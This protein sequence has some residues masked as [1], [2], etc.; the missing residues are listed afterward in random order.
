MPQCCCAR[1]KELSEPV[2]NN[3]YLHEPLGPRGN[4]CGPRIQHELRDA[5][6]RIEKLE[7]ERKTLGSD[8][9]VAGELYEMHKQRDALMSEIH[10]FALADDIDFENE[11]L[12]RAMDAAFPA[13]GFAEAV[14]LDDAAYKPNDVF[15]RHG[16]LVGHAI[17]DS[18]PHPTRRGF[19]LVKVALHT[20]MYET[21]EAP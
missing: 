13:C 19:H 3:D 8:I 12:G 5:R 6:R 21:A 10:A 17:C 4:F 16:R 1:Y 9:E 15:K 20:S 7:A 11:A 14:F 18:L 2:V